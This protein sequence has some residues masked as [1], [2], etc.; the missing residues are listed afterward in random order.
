[1]YFYLA[2]CLNGS[3]YFIVAY[4]YISNVDKLNSKFINIKSSI[5]DSNVARL[6]WTLTR[7]ANDIVTS[8]YMIVHS[9]RQIYLCVG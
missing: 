4:K 7:Y 1:M 3:I 5:F 6:K 9:P 2:D 8:A